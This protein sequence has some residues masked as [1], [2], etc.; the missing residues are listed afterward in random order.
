MANNEILSRPSLGERGWLLAQL[1]NE[2]VGGGILLFAAVVALVWANSPWGD[3]YFNMV[4]YQIGP[5]ALGLDLTLGVWA[6]D[7]LLAIFFFVVGLELKH[8]LI[9]GSLSKPAQ[10]VVPAAAA[11]GGM[12]VPALF[13]VVVNAM[14]PDGSLQGWGIPMATDIA[15]ALA[16]LAIFGRKLP[17][18]LRAFLLTLAVVDDL[19]AISVIAIFYSDKFAIVWFAA[20]LLALLAFWLL[21]KYRISSPI[22][23]IPLVVIGWYFCY[24][25]GVHATVAGIGFGF[26]TRVRLDPGEKKA[27]ADTLIH[28]IHPISAGFAIPVFALFAAGVDL[29]ATGIIEPLQSPVALGIMIGLVLGKPVGIVGMAWLMARFTRASLSPGIAWR[30]VTAVGF[31]AGV[32]FTV[33]LLISEL[34]YGGD[35][36]LLESAKIAVLVASVTSAV[37]AAFMLLSRGRHYA[38]IAEIEEAEQDQDAIPDEFLQGETES[39][40]KPR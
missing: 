34:G 33:A 21:Q 24:K 18:A 38:E 1:R 32:G 5:A 28:T 30:D 31:L 36:L 25:S 12:I 26:L 20:F 7:A 17:V 40:P 35:E 39:G 8:E 3:G 19:G 10:A 13:Y 15:F 4:D 6:A 23:Y 37:I 29:R 9:L 14:L 27:P 2:T 22:I 11:I 16:V